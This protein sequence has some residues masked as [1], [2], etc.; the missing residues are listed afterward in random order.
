MLGLLGFFFKTTCLE[1]NWQNKRNVGEIAA[2]WNTTFLRLRPSKRA[3]FL[4]DREYYKL[5]YGFSYKLTTLKG[6]FSPK[7]FFLIYLGCFEDIKDVCVLSNIKEVHGLWCSKKNQKKIF[8]QLCL[9]PEITTQFLEVIHRPCCEQLCQSCFLS[10]SQC[11]G[12]WHLFEA[13][14]ASKCLDCALNSVNK[15]L[16]TDLTD[17]FNYPRFIATQDMNV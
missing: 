17:W 1:A 3:L 11:R 6:L 5:N 4:S 14:A 10:V 12:K 2:L 8:K 13:R 9:F 7:C 16:E 15:G